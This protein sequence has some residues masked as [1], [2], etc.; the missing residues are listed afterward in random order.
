MWLFTRF[1]GRSANKEEV[2]GRGE[3]F[4]KRKQ[5]YFYILNKLLYYLIVNMCDL[6]N[7]ESKSFVD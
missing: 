7:K 2:G 4:K 1:Y 6:I 3:A 5:F